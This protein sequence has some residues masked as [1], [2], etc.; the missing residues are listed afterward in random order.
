[1]E[2]T[3][4]P[5]EVALA[6]TVVMELTTVELETDLDAGIMLQAL[7]VVQQVNVGQR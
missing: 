3:M 6:W 7:I 2:A 5:T 1:M 4:T